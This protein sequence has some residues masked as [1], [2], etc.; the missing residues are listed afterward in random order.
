MSL[1]LCNNSCISYLA[2]PN[3]TAS[4]QEQR[5]CIET[6]IGEHVIVNSLMLINDLVLFWWR[7]H[8]LTCYI[9]NV[10]KL[11]IWWCSPMGSIRIY[12]LNLNLYSDT[13]RVSYET[14]FRFE[15]TET[16][17]ETSFDTIRNN[18]FVS[19]VSVKYRNRQFR[20]FEWTEKKEKNRN[21]LKKV[22]SLL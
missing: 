20:C 13:A 14:N 6:S 11:K 21:N 5:P 9:S 3:G 22:L 7:V 8:V 18:T 1:S 12:V 10:N 15:T 2:G 19:V 16:G 4:P 17:T